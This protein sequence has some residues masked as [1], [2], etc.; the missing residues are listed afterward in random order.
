[1]QLGDVVVRAADGRQ[2]AMKDPETALRNAARIDSEAEAKAA[3]RMGIVDIDA[4]EGLTLDNFVA[5]E[6]GAAVC[7]QEKAQNLFGLLEPNMTGRVVP[8]G[9]GPNLKISAQLAEALFGPF[10]QEALLSMWQAGANGGIEL[11]VILP[12]S[13][14]KE[15]TAIPLKIF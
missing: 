2:L 14:K 3:G 8:E 15:R 12:L 6:V 4:A 11:E 1:M 10:N 5:S 9:C 13:K 7:D